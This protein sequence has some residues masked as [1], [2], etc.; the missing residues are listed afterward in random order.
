[1][2]D[3]ARGESFEH[4]HTRTL[5]VIQLLK[6]VYPNAKIALHYH[7]PWELLVAVILSA[8]CTDV[9]VNKVTDKLFQKYE[10]LADYVNVNPAE[11]EQDIKSTGFYHNKAKNILSSAEKIQKVFKSQVPKTME[12]VLTLPGVARKTGNVV[13]GNAYGV[14]VGIAVD[15]HVARISQRLRLVDMNAVGGKKELNFTKKSL[16]ILDYKKDADPGKIE[17]ELIQVIPKSDW[18][19]FTYLVIDHGRAVCKA[20]KPD[21]GRCILTKVCPASRV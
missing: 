3:A 1:M 7:N 15:T 5:Q 2:T 20:Q 21:C 17:T 10:T 11:F 4:R 12:E 13:L 18:F 8:Q 6:S 9:T 16:K 14:V 19:K